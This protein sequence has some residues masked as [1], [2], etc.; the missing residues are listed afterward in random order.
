MQILEIPAI[1]KDKKHLQSLINEARHRAM[2]VTWLW[3]AVWIVAAA[4]AI[5]ACS[6][7]TSSETDQTQAVEVIEV[8]ET[9]ETLTHYLPFVVR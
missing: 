6:Y 2:V 4:I 9:V 7:F 8:V 5:G 1:P 3:R